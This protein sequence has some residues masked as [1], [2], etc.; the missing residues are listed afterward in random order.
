MMR[1]K[2]VFLSLSVFWGG[3]ERGREERR[4]TGEMRMRKSVNKGRTKEM[5]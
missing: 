5:K 2:S 1:R 4:R 3:R